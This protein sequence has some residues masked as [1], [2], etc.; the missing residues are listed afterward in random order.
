PHYHGYD[1]GFLRWLTLHDKQPDFLAD[2]DLE[3][4]TGDDLARAY[5]LVIF[6]GHEEYA[7]QHAYDAVRRYRDLGGNLAFLSANN[8]FYRVLKRATTI[9][10]VER[11]RDV[12]RPESAIVGAQ[13]R[14][15]NHG[16][17]PNQPFVVEGVEHAPWLL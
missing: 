8:L 7:T 4:L 12:G 6:S 1:R 17:Y 15:W 3:H 16:R 9:E 10:R 13:Y 11:F 14:D 2:D 5:D